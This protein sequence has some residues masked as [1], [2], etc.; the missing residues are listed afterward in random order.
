VDIIN[1]SLGGNFRAW[2]GTPVGTVVNDLAERGFV[3]VV[4]ASDLGENGLFTAGDPDS[5]S[6]IITVGD[7]NNIQFL[8]FVIV[9]SNDPK[10]EISKYILYIYNVIK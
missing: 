10:K 4:S 1:I 8:S 3:I 2:D 5:S 9:P 7:V 6:K